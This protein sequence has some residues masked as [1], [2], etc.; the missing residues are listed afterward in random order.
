MSKDGGSLFGY[1]DASG[2]GIGYGMSETASNSH[3]NRQ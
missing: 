3:G 2:H 1:Q